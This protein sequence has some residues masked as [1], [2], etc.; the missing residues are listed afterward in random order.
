VAG[1]N[2]PLE[3]EVLK[4][5]RQALHLWG[6]V[7]WRTNSGRMRVQRGGKEH[8]YRF[9][10]ADGCADL[11]GLIPKLSDGRTGVFFACEAKR[12]GGKTTPAQESFL[13]MIRKAGGI[14]CVASSVADLERAL[15]D[16]GYQT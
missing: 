16:A 3:K 9:N 4:Q 7:A 14:A 8:F 11:V 10:G 6:V 12:P 15:N 2:V 13:E 5:L 1:K